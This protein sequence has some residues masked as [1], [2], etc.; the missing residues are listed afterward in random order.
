[1]GTGGRPPG[2]AEREEPGVF[3]T[4]PLLVTR[5]DNSPALADGDTPLATREGV[6][7]LAPIA[8]FVSRC[9]SKADLGPQ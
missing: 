3:I 4:R 1:M 9:V 5:V 7:M 8:Y 6:E 2:V